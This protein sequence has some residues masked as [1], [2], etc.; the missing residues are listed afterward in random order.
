VRVCDIVD[1]YH[2]TSGGIRTYIDQK[3]RFLSATGE[4][5]HV[6]IIPT[7]RD[8]HEQDG[9]TQVFGI[10][11]PRI[12]GCGEY[13]ALLRERRVLA[14]LDETHPDV[15]EWANPYLHP[16]AVSHAR[17][18]GSA[19]TA[20]YYHT[21][22]PVAYVETPLRPLVGNRVARAA[23][24]LALRYARGV[25][26]NLDLTLVSSPDMAQALSDAGLP[27]VE[28]LPLGVDTEIFHP[29][30][31]DP[32]WRRSLGV[33]DR[34]LLLVFAGRFDREK[35]VDVLLEMARRLPP[36]LPWKLLFIGDGPQR[37]MLSRAAAED[38]RVLV[39]PFERERR[40]FAR[41]LA[42]ADIYV[43]AARFET[44]GLS[45]IEAQASGLPVVGQRA[46]AMPDRVPPSA[47]ILV[48]ELDPGAMADA[49][50][51][52]A[53]GQRIAMGQAARRMVVEHST[54]NRTF[55]RLIHLYEEAGQTAG[56]S[57]HVGEPQHA[58]RSAHA[59]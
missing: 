42:S 14:I 59:H 34:D 4:H 1:A 11:S 32:S 10:A 56:R 46:G 5:E 25:H 22:F 52:I 3:T 2:A 36:A 23:R 40:R 39:L 12:P 48:D 31:R 54:W 6:L 21:D 19:V 47:G 9:L 45:V 26:T 15:V 35:R 57:G 53:S 27:R 55:E 33:S 38:P 8:F 50:T 58:E 17:R 37:P 16:W 28:I 13:R 41:C 30:R 29:D 18:R 24:R 7:D 49:V 43:S 44:F 20:G 51:R